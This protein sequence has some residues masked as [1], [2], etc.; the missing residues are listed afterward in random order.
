MPA[1]TRFVK[2]SHWTLC[3]FS[4]HI[5]SIWTVNCCTGNSK[6]A[7]QSK[8]EQCSKSTTSFNKSKLLSC[9]H[10]VVTHCHARAREH[11]VAAPAIHPPVPLSSPFPIRMNYIC[12]AG[13]HDEPS[14]N[15]ESDR[16]DPRKSFITE[17]NNWIEYNTLTI[18]IAISWADKRPPRK[19]QAIMAQ[20]FSHF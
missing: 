17:T 10:V 18:P 12:A 2:L 5:C 1:K 6:Y 19:K 11:W 20:R 7:P 8:Y 15:T 14:C 4:F 13:Q 9:F 16:H 3:K